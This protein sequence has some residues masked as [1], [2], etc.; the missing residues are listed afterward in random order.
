MMAR[1]FAVS[2]VGLAAM[3]V[4]TACVEPLPNGVV[5]DVGVTKQPNG[6]NDGEGYLC[7]NPD[8]LADAKLQKGKKETNTWRWQQD[9]S[10]ICATALSS[11]PDTTS[12]RWRAIQDCQPGEKYI[13]GDTC[14]NKIIR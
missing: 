8:F 7:V 10:V 9:D 13:S 4:L 12:V 1:R 11:D 2:V 6:P 14:E 3:L 5:V